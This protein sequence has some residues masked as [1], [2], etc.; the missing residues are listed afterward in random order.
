MVEVYL[1]NGIGISGVQPK[2]MVPT[3]SS[4]PMADLIVKSAGKDFPGLAANEYLCLRAAQLAGLEVPRF[5]L[6]DDANLLLIDR[7]DIRSDGARIGFE[8]LA[9]LLGLRVNDRLDN[10][11]Y[12]G[13]YQLVAET[14][15]S[16]STNRTADLNSFFKQ[17]SLSVMVRNGDAHLK[18]FGMLYDGMADSNVRLSPLFDVVTTTIYKHERPGGFEHVDRTMALKM[19]RGKHATRAYPVTRDLLAFGRQVCRVAEPEQVLTRIGRAMTQ[20]LDQS[21]S[22]PRIDSALLQKIATEWEAGIAAGS[23]IEK[24][25]RSTRRLGS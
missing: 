7:F 14:I 22:D 13:S 8:D 20:V 24:S 18:N 17:L 16:Y 15:G 23:E 3:K 1:S 4:L 2:I 9:A 25:S 19:Q 12:L 11:K 5:E 10:R 21:R 6:S